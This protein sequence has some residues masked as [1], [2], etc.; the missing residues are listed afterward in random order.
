MD[1]VRNES[2]IELVGVVIPIT[3]RVNKAVIMVRT[4]AAHGGRE[5]TK[6]SEGVTAKN[7]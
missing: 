5:T 1:C 3:N 6:E 2:I 4:Y 7:R